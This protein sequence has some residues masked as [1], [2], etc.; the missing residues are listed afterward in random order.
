MSSAHW[1]VNGSFVRDGDPPNIKIDGNGIIYSPTPD[2]GNSLIYL[3]DGV[4]ADC[5]ANRSLSIPIKSTNNVSCPLD[6][7]GG[8][9]RANGHEILII[10]EGTVI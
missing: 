4:N 2:G 8:I 7:T 10:V 3:I 1:C 6:S 5:G 9:I